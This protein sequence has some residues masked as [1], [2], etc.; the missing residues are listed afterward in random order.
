MWLRLIVLVLASVLAC[1]A[2]GPAQSDQKI[3][4]HEV[5]A[6]IDERAIILSLAVFTKHDFSF[7]VI[8]N[9]GGNDTAKYPDLPTALEANGCAAGCNGGFFSRQPFA[10]VGG[11]ISAGVQVSR[12]NRRSW[13]KGLFVVRQGRPSLESVEDFKSN[14]GVSDLLQSGTWL[15]RNGQSETDNSRDKIARRTFLGH[16]IFGRWVLGACSP[17]TLHELAAA[18]RAPEVVAVINFQTALNLDG[19]PSTGL[20]LKQSP[21]NFYLQELWP[22]RNYVGI[23]PRVSP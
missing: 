6:T 14:T 10:P 12:I 2:D 9:A 18:L 23:S 3:T 19:G 15:V 21:D 17:C 16:D 13:M 22:V 1:F 7:R 8:D 4:L 5:R 11:M 20:W